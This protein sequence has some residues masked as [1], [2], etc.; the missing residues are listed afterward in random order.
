MF[1]APLPIYTV[2]TVSM[3]TF[4]TLAITYGILAATFFALELICYG[5]KR[6]NPPRLTAGGQA[7]LDRC[8]LDS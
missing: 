3:S 2:R 6:M 5:V 7:R 1:S 4:R 8:H